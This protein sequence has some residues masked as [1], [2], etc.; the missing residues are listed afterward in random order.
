[1][2]FISS[3]LI[4]CIL[5]VVISTPIPAHTDLKASSTPYSFST[6]V[7]ISKVDHVY[8]S[9]QIDSEED[10][11]ISL[12][13]EEKKEPNVYPVYKKT[14]GYSAEKIVPRDDYHGSNIPF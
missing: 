2:N 3:F 6:I 8:E 11:Q 14:K 9:L 13:L 12:M 5:S 7:P 4:L 1:M 10:D